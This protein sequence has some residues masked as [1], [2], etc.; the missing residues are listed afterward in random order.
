MNADLVIQNARVLTLAGDAPRRGDAMND[1]AILPQADVAV[2]NGRISAVGPDLAGDAGCRID[3]AGRVLMPGLIDCH[4]H[5]CWAGVRYDELDRLGRGESYL[6]ILAAGGGIMAT[7]R[8]VRDAS[9][10]R[11]AELTASRFARMASLGA[12]TIECKS[13]YG[14]ATDAELKMLRAI[15]GAEEMASIRVIPTALVAHAIDKDNPRFIDE[16]IEE[17]VPRVAEHFP[18]ICLDAYCEEGAWSVEQTVRLFEKGRSLGLPCRVHADQFHSLGM[19]EAAI[20]LGA[21]S[22]DHLEASTDDDLKRLAASDTMGVML[23]VSAFHLGDA[24]APGRRF[25]DM[26]GALAIAT[27]HNPGTGPSPSMPFTLALAVKHLGVTP[28]EAIVA[29]TINAAAVLHLQREIGSIEV[30]KHADMLLLHTTD[31]RQLVYEFAGDPI[32]M[33]I[34]S[35]EIVQPGF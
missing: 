16:T 7:V 27:N 34:R 26:G 3:A 22:V 17:T 14:L 13:G 19:V 18:G 2:M 15:A 31:E 11:L 1:L 24:H 29:G 33:I 10:E 4:T 20:S 25:I 8:A 9:V 23:P 30:G 21:R 28:A 5:A 6:D 35:G 12:T 32:A